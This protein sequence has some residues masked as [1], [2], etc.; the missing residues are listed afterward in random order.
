MSDFLFLHDMIFKRLLGNKCGCK[1]HNYRMDKY[2]FS[3]FSLKEV[4]VL[5]RRNKRLS[6]CLPD[7]LRFDEFVLQEHLQN[8]GCKTPFQK[9]AQTEKIC[10]S[11][12]QIKRANFDF[13]KIRNVKESC[14]L[15]MAINF[16]YEKV[17][18][19]VNGKDWFNVVVMFPDHYEEIVMVQAVD[20]H[21]AIGNSGGYIGLFLGNKSY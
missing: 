9:T 11:K 20:I 15:P 19:Q 14:T 16:D 10:E 1:H 8:I 5:R 13:L 7:D 4:N 21:S 2:C 18:W 12:E 6:P 17:N 3:S